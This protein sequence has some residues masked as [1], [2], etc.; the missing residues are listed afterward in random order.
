MKVEGLSGEVVA[1]DDTGH[2]LGQPSDC[3][4]RLFIPSYSI[5]KTVAIWLQLSGVAGEGSGL[6]TTPGNDGESWG[7]PS[8][9]PRS[10]YRVTGLWVSDSCRVTGRVVTPTGLQ[11]LRVT[12]W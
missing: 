3:S 9:R 12:G 8:S 5:E 2:D 10:Q 1:S 4:H 7:H 11:G 6:L